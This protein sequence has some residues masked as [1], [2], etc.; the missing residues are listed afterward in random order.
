MTQQNG[1]AG[2]ARLFDLSPQ[3]HRLLG[4]LGYKPPSSGGSLKCGVSPRLN[5]MQGESS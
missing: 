5:P 3:E 2:R 1:G 4:V